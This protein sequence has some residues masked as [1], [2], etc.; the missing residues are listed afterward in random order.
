MHG[1]LNV[2]NVIKTF[3]IHYNGKFKKIVKEMQYF[4]GML[5]VESMLYSNTQCTMF[6]P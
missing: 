5:V 2:M 6:F 3:R 4:L 1:L